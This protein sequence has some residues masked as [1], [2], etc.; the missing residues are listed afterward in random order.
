MTRGFQVFV[1]DQADVAAKALGSGAAPM[2]SASYIGRFPAG[3][4]R[5]ERPCTHIRVM[6]PSGVVLSGAAS[7]LG[8]RLAPYSAN[9]AQPPASWF[10]AGGALSLFL[11]TEDSVIHAVSPVRRQRDVDE[12]PMED[13][14][15]VR[16]ADG[17]RPGALP[18]PPRGHRCPPAENQG[19]EIAK[20]LDCLSDFRLSDITPPTKRTGWP[21]GCRYPAVVSAWCP[22][23]PLCRPPRCRPGRAATSS[24]L[25]FYVGF[26]F[27]GPRWCPRRLFSTRYSDLLAARGRSTTPRVRPFLHRQLPQDHTG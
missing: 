5:G 16:G 8:R 10:P 4:G 7:L 3:G 26:R 15:R 12:W 25:D 21:G 24:S 17:S 23:L 13:E 11:C 19:R 18:R 9:W 6:F 1:S 27:A 22:P 2:S 20:A 14:A